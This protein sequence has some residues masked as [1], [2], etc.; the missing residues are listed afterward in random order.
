M[1]KSAHGPQRSEEFHVLQ[2]TQFERK[3]KKVHLVPSETH[4]FEVIK[5]SGVLWCFQVSDRDVFH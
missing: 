3:Q 1:L 2:G 5:T 4:S